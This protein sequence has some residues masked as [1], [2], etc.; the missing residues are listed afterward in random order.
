LKNKSDFPFVIEQHPTE[1]T[2]YPFITLI[3]YQTKRILL[4]VDNVSKRTIKGY[5]VD[6]CGQESIDEEQLIS[7]A[8]DWYENH[9]EV[10]PVS[11]EFHKQGVFN[12]TSK[13][14]KSFSIEKISRYIGPMFIYEMD[15]IT[16]IRRRKRKLIP[17]SIIV[18]EPIFLLGNTD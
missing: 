7:I 3:Q 12:G 17:A 5:V 6:L 10:H 9:R 15:E 8:A 11:I 4:I 18:P 2:G 14:Y 13:L 16:K 1:Y